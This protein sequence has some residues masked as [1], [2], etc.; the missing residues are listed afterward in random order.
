MGNL[1]GILQSAT[2]S[3][4]SY[5]QALAVIQNNIANAATPGYARQRVSLAPVLVPG[6]SQA[7]GVE[8][9]R[10]QSLR[11]SL[12]ESQV[13]L[14]AQSKS[15]YEKSS[16]IFESVEPIF[17]LSGGDSIGENIDQFFSAVSALTVLPEDFNLRR[18]VISAADALAGAFRATNAELAQ[19]RTNLDTDATSVI[20]RVNVLIEEAAE[21][22][23]K[24]QGGASDT[25]NFAAETRLT[26]VLDELSGLIGFRT[27][28]QVDGTFTLVS[29]D[30]E[31]LIVGP[32][33][34]PLTVALGDEQ[35]QIFDSRGN[36]ITSSFRTRE[37]SL[38]A[39]LESRNTLLPRYLDQINRL[40]KSV[41]DQVNEQLLRG[42]TL[43]GGPGKEI[44]QYTTSYF[45]G[46]GRTAGTAGAATPAPPTSIDVV[47]SGGV[48]GAISADLD[49]FFVAAAPPAGPAAGDTLSITFTSADGSV[50]RTLTTAALLGGEDAAALA[51]RLNDQASLDPQLAGLVTFSD[52]GGQLKLVLSDQAGQGFSF[53][54]STSNLAFTSGLEAGGTLGGHSAGEIA[55]AL[56]AE[57]ALD[58]ALSAAGLRF[59]GLNGEVRLD[60]DVAFDFTVTDNDPAATGFVSGLAGADSAG[61]APAAATIQLAAISPAEVAAGT[62]ALPAGND[63]LRLIEALPGAKLIGGFRFNNF[64]ANLVAEVGGA[65]SAASSQLHTKEQLLLAAQGIRDSFSGVDI[66]EEA[67]QLVQFEKSFSAMLRIIQVVDGL[68]AEVL[69]LVR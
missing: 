60:G 41:A 29:A 34:Y 12:L 51:T 6:G 52:A 2:R 62:F 36:D 15:F 17:R 64:F 43:T 69:N 10:V 4:S 49:G 61:G 35:I 42:A 47:F 18:S 53:T 31:P 58:P 48:T 13:L 25:P 3:L 8:V 21:L 68:M 55:A 44:F 46:A 1:S 39:V 19:Q 38:G 50:E 59:V 66:N 63:N 27:L 28:T 22:G 32:T 11:D 16:Q 45:Q 65:S 56:N 20:Q 23:V 67:V 40:A 54:S 26:Q 9:V 33:T 5:S 14:A 7:L 37:G 57:V 24:R 30:G